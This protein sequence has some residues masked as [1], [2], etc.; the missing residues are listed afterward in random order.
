MVNC[1]KI[2][3]VSLILGIIFV[4][5]FWFNTSQDAIAMFLQKEGTTAK[6][7]FLVGKVDVRHAGSRQWEP[8]RESMVLTKGAKIK[9]GKDGRLELILLDGSNIQLKENS[10]LT[11]RNLGIN[12]RGNRD[13]LLECR[14]G[15][16]RIEVME[17]DAASSFK[18]KT[19]VA[20]AGV[21]GTLFFMDV[22][23]TSSKLFVD[24]NSKGVWFENTKTGRG[25][26]VREGYGSNTYRDGSIRPPQMLSKEERDEW[27]Q[28]WNPAL[29]RKYLSETKQKEDTESEDTESEDDDSDEGGEGE[30][31]SE[32][33][34]EDSEG[35]I[36]DDV[37]SD[38]NDLLRGTTELGWEGENEE[39]EDEI[40]SGDDSGLDNDEDGL[41]NGEERLLGTEVDNPDTDGD[42][43]EDGDEV[44]T[45]GT[46]P[47]VEDTDEDGLGD[48]AEVNTHQTNPLS[49]DTDDDEL[50]D[51][52]EVKYGFDPTIPGE[53]GKDPDEDKLTNLQEQY[54]DINP[55]NGDTDGDS[56]EDRDDAFPAPFAG[57]DVEAEE[58]VDVM[59]TRY[60]IR[61]FLFADL[62]A[63][64]LLNQSL[65]ETGNLDRE[66]EDCS[67]FEWKYKVNMEDGPFGDIDDFNLE[68]VI[69]PRII[70]YEE[71]EFTGLLASEE[72]T[73]SES[74]DPSDL[75]DRSLDLVYAV[76][77]DD[78][79]E[80]DD[81]LDDLRDALWDEIEDIREGDRWRQ[82]DDIMTHISDAQMGKVMTDRLG[83]RV[84]MEQ[85]ILRPA[86]KTVQF[87][88]INQRAG[89]GS[90]RGLTVLDW[91]TNF[92][93]AVAGSELKTLP[94]D[95]YLRNVRVE[96]DDG[97]DYATNAEGHYYIASP[98]EDKFPTDMK[99]ALSHINDSNL[100]AK[101]LFEVT[102][103]GDWV[104]YNGGIQPIEYCLFGAGM[105]QVFEGDTGGFMGILD[106]L[107]EKIDRN[108]ERQRD[109]I[110]GVTA[111]ASFVYTFNDDS[112]NGPQDPFIVQEASE[113][114]EMEK[115]WGGEGELGLQSC[116]LTSNFY[117]INDSG[118]VD[119]GRD[120]DSIGNLRDALHVGFFQLERGENLEMEFMLD[121]YRG[122]DATD[123]KVE[124][125]DVP[126]DMV[127]APAPIPGD[128]HGDS[129]W[130]WNEVEWEVT[131]E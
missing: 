105:E 47:L 110:T 4:G 114:W 120:I 40:I 81:L 64:V 88:S 53:T 19:P 102:K 16:L 6:I 74:D 85:Y 24:K 28:M 8:G 101:F 131:E 76:A 73:G 108:Y 33:G 3:L 15:K 130:K 66:E 90:S 93:E 126:I 21:R 62:L 79:I 2:A 41:T 125:F 49:D 26:L 55:L 23:G 13:T 107:S 54:W 121:G 113:S 80:L 70:G 69:R 97:W 84:R 86:A 42:G 96:N 65:P 99:I 35:G 38:I 75:V 91:R 109:P 94:W 124:M 32:E 87:L 34:G 48:G 100:S 5:S 117:V 11:I 98:H 45:Y 68:N 29:F 50:K 56:I 17:L 128:S 95:K 77:Y 12:S 44:N 116:R 59:E 61:V 51:G 82:M 10:S 127:I 67:W 36:G 111:N 103:F 9:T 71:G 129:R 92:N 63:G 123:E 57:E 22:S 30:D 43:L 104:D 112:T 31:S 27:R 60:P 20:V 18:I 52:F 14:R 37:F 115:G 118:I 1:K 25:Y 46:E 58:D 119:G 122:R 72:F 83:Y 39:D 106:G 89:S 7:S 78:E